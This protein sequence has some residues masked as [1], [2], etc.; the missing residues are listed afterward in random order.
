M[1]WVQGKVKRS[2]GVSEGYTGEM[3]SERRRVG[4]FRS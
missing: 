2:M 4:S 1:F 3:G